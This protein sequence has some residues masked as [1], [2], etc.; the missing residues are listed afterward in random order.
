MPEHPIL[1]NGEMV[2]AILEGRKTETRRPLRPQP[3]AGATEVAAEYIFEG[4][5][6]ATY[7]AYPDGGTARHGI[8][9]SPFGVPG[10]TLWVR[11]AWGVG[12]RPDPH[13]GWREGVEYRADEEYLDDDRDLLA[14][15]DVTPPDDVELEEYIG[16]W[17]PSINMPRW[18]SRITLSVESVWVERIQNITDAGCLA[19]ALRGDTYLEEL[20]TTQ[21]DPRS[22][23]IYF[24][25]GWDSIYA[26]RGF[27]WETNLWVWECRFGVE[28]S[29]A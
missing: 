5:L 4:E 23:R 9:S 15:Y 19:A 12:T 1:F 11:E 2:R 26:K 10:D 6:A 27:G 22:R 13:E 21:D 8:T 20:G 18:A 24:M 14:L 3:P 28:K 29:D 7:R 17:H 16:H 25:E